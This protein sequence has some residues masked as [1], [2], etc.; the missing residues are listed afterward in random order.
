MKEKKD[1][2]YRD[3]FEQMH[4]KPYQTPFGFPPEGECWKLT[5]AGDGGYYWF[6][7]A[8]DRYNIKIHDF[9]FREDTVLNMQI[10]EALSV[11]W[12]ESISGEEL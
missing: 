11:T 10:P 12:Y 8:G 3:L 9:Y 6:Y 5:E 2:F 7:E 1:S 4:F